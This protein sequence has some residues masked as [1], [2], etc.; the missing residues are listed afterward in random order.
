MLGPLKYAII[1]RLVALV[2]PAS[3]P[4]SELSQFLRLYGCINFSHW[5]SPLTTLP[6]HSKVDSFLT[7]LRV[8]QEFYGQKDFIPNFYST[9]KK[10]IPL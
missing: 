3:L 5:H 9:L 4:P 6:I 7:G 1:L 2:F 10:T 8:L